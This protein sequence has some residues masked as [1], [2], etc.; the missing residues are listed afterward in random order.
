MRVLEWKQGKH[1]SSCRA[2]MAGRSKGGLV[3]AHYHQKLS[4][5]QQEG[6]VLARH[7]RAA[8]GGARHLSNAQGTEHDVFQPPASEFYHPTLPLSTPPSRR[9]AHTTAACCTTQHCTGP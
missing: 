8:A 2:G 7:A 9:H 1:H 5:E 4:H 3:E 6:N